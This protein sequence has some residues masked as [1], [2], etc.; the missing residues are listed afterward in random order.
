VEAD[1][2]AFLVV[3]L[4]VDVDFVNGLVVDT[5]R[6]FL[7]DV[8]DLF[9]GEGRFAGTAKEFFEMSNFLIID[10]EELLHED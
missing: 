3:I 2:N 6:G 10:D 1:F 5:V 7:D 9:A 8:G 4:R